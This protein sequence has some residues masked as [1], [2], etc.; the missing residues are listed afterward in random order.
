[1]T[2]SLVV[3][4][5][6]ETLPGDRKKNAAFALLPLSKPDMTFPSA[7]PSWGKSIAHPLGKSKE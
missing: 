6:V 7:M 5:S 3:S 1:M 4:A 2:F